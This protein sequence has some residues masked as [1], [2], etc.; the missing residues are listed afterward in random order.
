MLFNIVLTALASVLAM[1]WF[2]TR[3]I[4][5]ELATQKTNHIEAV[6]LLR[7][8]I[9]ALKEMHEDRFEK[10]KQLEHDRRLYEAGKKVWDYFMGVV[11]T[12][13]TD[14]DHINTWLMPDITAYQLIFVNSDSEYSEQFGKLV[15][16]F[17]K[18]SH[19]REILIS[20]NSY[21]FDELKKDK[22]AS[23]E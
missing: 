18:K 1:W 9:K 22:V 16:D 2:Q 6:K 10:D 7:K 20:G 3:K 12:Q 15:V 21:S 11:K 14:T 13:A 4:N 23:L 17:Q 19:E 8:E 5:I